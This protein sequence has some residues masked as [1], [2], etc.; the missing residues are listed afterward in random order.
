[1][2][3]SKSFP[4]DFSLQC[5]WRTNQNKL[6]LYYMVE[7]H[8]LISNISK[9]S[10]RNRSFSLN[11]VGLR[12]LMQSRPPFPGPKPKSKT[13]SHFHCLFW[14]NLW[15]RRLSRKGKLIPMLR[16]ELTWD[17][18][19]GFKGWKQK[20]KGSLWIEH[21]SMFS[22]IN[23]IVS[24]QSLKARFSGWGNQILCTDL[25]AFGM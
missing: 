16:A 15:M 19:L 4:N 24:L 25:S 23:H 8:S 21:A 22:N 18:F 7:L 3:I 11:N 20:P 9:Q 2:G 12:A 5:P 6:A 1:M 17:F 10:G 14:A 13:K